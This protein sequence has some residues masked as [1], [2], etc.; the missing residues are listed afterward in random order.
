MDNDYKHDSQRRN[1]IEGEFVWIRNE[2][3]QELIKVDNNE[4][5]CKYDNV[6][7]WSLKGRLSGMQFINHEKKR[8]NHGFIEPTIKIELVLIVII[9]PL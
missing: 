1:L 6:S 9:P 5:K 4:D 2:I 3:N 7:K 8:S